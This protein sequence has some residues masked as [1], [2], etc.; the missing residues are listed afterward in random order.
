M[1]GMVALVAVIIEPPLSSLSVMT[2]KHDDID[3]WATDIYTA[4]PREYECKLGVL[5]ELLII[6]TSYT[7]S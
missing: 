5:K 2:W 1:Y 4:L 3:S 7:A 6:H